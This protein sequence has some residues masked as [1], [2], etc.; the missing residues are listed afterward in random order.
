MIGESDCNVCSLNEVEFFDDVPKQITLDKGCW[1][2]LHP[3]SVL[4]STAPIEFIINGSTDELLDPNSCMLQLR[5]KIVNAVGDANLRDTDV[6]AP[7][8]NW[9]HSCFSDVIVTIGGTQVEGGNGTYPYKSYFINLFTHS[10]GSKDTHLQSVGWYK[11]TTGH[12][13]SAGPNNTGFTARQ[14][15]KGNSVTVELCG[16]LNADIFL[17]NKYLLHNVDVGIKLIPSKPAFQTM[18][19]TAAD[20]NGR[21]TSLKVV[22]EKAVLY[23]RRVKALP[24]LINS[25]EEKLNGQNGIWPSQRTELLTYTVPQGQSSH[26]R[27]SLFRGQMPKLVLI[28]LVRNDAYNGD[29]A[30]N[31]FNFQ[32]FGINSLALYREGESIPCRPFTP[33]FANNL[34]QREYVS[35]MQSLDLFNKNENIDLTHKEFKEGY[36]IF[37]F[38][39]TPDL[40]I[41]GHSQ[42]YRDGNIRLEIG[43]STALTH[44][45]NVIVMGIF[46]AKLEITK[47]R[48]VLMDWKS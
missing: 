23:V 20:V 41:A 28:G 18:I 1:V 5:L 32:N 9:F 33:D 37:G 21:A 6:V 15:L 43:F 19:K 36:T 45:V 31:P 25:I 38:N 40:V 10:K 11:D 42:P 30:R 24:S 46:D 47:Y 44:T 2:D 17:Q 34:Y 16:P 26:N 7:V 27:E 12:M 13:D 48:N 3:L 4:S 22:Y 8:N 29:Y 35:L 14:E 39:L